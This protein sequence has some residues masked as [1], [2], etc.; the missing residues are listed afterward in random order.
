M[1]TERAQSEPASDEKIFSDFTVEEVQRRAQ[2]AGVSPEELNENYV[3][4]VRKALD[5]AR[6]WQQRYQ[7]QSDSGKTNAMQEMAQLARSLAISCRVYVGSIVFDITQE[8]LGKLFAPYGHIK[9]IDMSYDKVTNKHKG[10]AF[11]EYEVPDA[12]AIAIRKLNGSQLGGRPLKVGRPNN[13]PTNLPNAGLPPGPPERI[14]IGNVHEGVTEKDLQEVFEAFGTIR[15]C[16]LVPDPISQKHKGYGFIEFTDGTAA[17]AA[18]LTMDEFDL[19]GKPLAVCKCICGTLLPTGMSS[20]PQTSSSPAVMNGTGSTPNPKPVSA[21]LA[22]NVT[23]VL[24]NIVKKNNEDSLNREENVSVTGT[25]RWEIMQKLAREE[26]SKTL[27]LKN[28]VTK[29]DI[30]EE[31]ESEV[32]SECAK[33]GEVKQVKLHFPEEGDFV[34]VYVQFGTG[35]EAAKA[36]Q[37]FNGRFFS[38]NLIT[39]QH[40]DNDRFEAGDLE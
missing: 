24:N 17:D 33:Y 37:V 30:D 16:I 11:V 7:I 31:F 29:E 1:A 18:A 40:Y 34:R 19:G 15:A 36:L 35:G 21:V 39:A 8:D 10:Y 20:V 4:Q 12:A 27:V 3:D 32:R 13:F 14:Y 2:R 22:Q 26:P 6:S 28:M 23:A 9:L 38:G 25:L 5:F